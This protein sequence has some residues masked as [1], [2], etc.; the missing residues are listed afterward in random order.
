MTQQRMYFREIK[1]YAVPDSLEALRGPSSG[2]V[3]LPMWVYWAPGERTFDVGTRSGAK[4]AYVAVLSEGVLDEV[5][6]VV[7]AQRLKQLWDA[8]VIPRRARALWEQQF[9][10]LVTG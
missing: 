3:T 9:P 8:M 1:P 4:R 5:C 6:E 10:E 2:L 7:N